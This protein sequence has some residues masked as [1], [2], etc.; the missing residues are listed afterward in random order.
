MVRKNRGRKVK[1]D[2]FGKES[3]HRAIVK[4]LQEAL[5]VTMRKSKHDLLSRHDIDIVPKCQVKRVG[6]TFKKLKSGKTYVCESRIII[7]LRVKYLHKL[8]VVRDDSYEVFY[9]DET[10]INAHHV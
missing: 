8:K 4:L 9:L 6:F 1:V 7:C 3:T 2:S 5:K 10:N